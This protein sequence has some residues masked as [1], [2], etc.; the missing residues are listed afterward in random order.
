MFIS[1]QEKEGLFRRLRE[2]EAAAANIDKNLNATHT[3]IIGHLETCAT[4]NREA[5][6]ERQQF[7]REMRSYFVGVTVAL[8]TIA[9]GVLFGHH[10]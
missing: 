7:R 8:A 2:A 4:Q 5:S 10:I 1:S 3:I 6:Q 9:A